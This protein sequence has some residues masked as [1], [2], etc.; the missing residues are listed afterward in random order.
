MWKSLTEIM[1]NMMWEVKFVDKKTGELIYRN[2][3]FH[4]EA[5]INAIARKN[6]WQIV[7]MKREL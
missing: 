5:Q 7:R 1:E 3:K 4:D 6:K 2:Y